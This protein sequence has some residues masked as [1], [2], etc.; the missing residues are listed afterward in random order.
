MPLAERLQVALR[1][2]SLR[3]SYRL[4]ALQLLL[5]FGVLRC[6]RC[7]HSKLPPLLPISLYAEVCTTH[8]LLCSAT[9]YLQNDPALPHCVWTV[10][11]AAPG[12]TEAPKFGLPVMGLELDDPALNLSGHSCSARDS[13]SPP[14]ATVAGVNDAAHSAHG[15]ICRLLGDLDDAR[16]RTHGLRDPSSGEFTCVCLTIGHGDDLSIQF[17][18]TKV[19]PQHPEHTQTLREGLVHK[20]SLRVEGGEQNVPKNIRS[21]RWRS[22]MGTMWCDVCAGAKNCHNAGQRHDW[23]TTRGAAR[24]V[25]VQMLDRVGNCR[26]SSAGAAWQGCWSAARSAAPS[27]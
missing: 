14:M 8:T 27:C 5:Y 20:P 26:R 6:H 1:L 4:S 11:G 12:R 24:T 19:Q 9:L 21:N 22:L 7:C 10:A 16:V 13:E 25:R 18:A 23:A 17:V 3:F 15:I 2:S